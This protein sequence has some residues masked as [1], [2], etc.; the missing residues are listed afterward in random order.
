MKCH[1]QIKHDTLSDEGK[2]ITRAIR[3][4]K[5]AFQ[6]AKEKYPAEAI[7]HNNAVVS[8]RAHKRYVV[9]PHARTTHLA[10]GFLK[11]TAY[12]EM[13]RF[14]RK[15]VNFGEIAGLAARF[16]TDA[17]FKQLPGKDNQ[18]L[19]GAFKDWEKAAGSH[20]NNMAKTHRIELAAAAAIR[21]EERAKQPAYVR[22]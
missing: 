13:E 2:R 10:L 22:T 3:K 14:S 21:T 6:R 18:A 17:E 4:H 15:D 19:L 1:L 9:K 5:A 11:G 8:M 20:R 16:C 7:R 12:A